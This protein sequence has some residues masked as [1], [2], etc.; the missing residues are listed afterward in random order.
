MKIYIIHFTDSFGVERIE[1]VLASSPIEA[2]RS[3]RHADCEII[4]R[5]Y[6]I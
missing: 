1:N 3:V 4:D 5:V 6:P 2:L